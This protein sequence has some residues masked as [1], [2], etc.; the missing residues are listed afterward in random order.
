MFFGGAP[1][2]FLLFLFYLFCWGLRPAIFHSLYS[3][4][5]FFML[6]EVLFVTYRKIPFAGAYDPGKPNL[7]L[8]WMLYLVGFIQYLVSF[9]S[10]ALMLLL[11]P[12]YY[13]LFFAAAMGFIALLVSKR[14]EMYRDEDF[15]FQYDEEGPEP[16]MMTLNIST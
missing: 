3:A 1:L 16:L 15:R 10:I 6:L 12:K 2:F 8:H 14:Y 7:K 9:T 11:N 13:I 4:A 5:I